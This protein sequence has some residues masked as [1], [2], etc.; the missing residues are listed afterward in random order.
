MS[1]KNIHSEKLFKKKCKYLPCIPN[2]NVEIIYY[3]I[4]RQLVS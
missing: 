4:I 3:L 1:T 2:N